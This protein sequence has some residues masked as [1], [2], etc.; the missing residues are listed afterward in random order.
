MAAEEALSNP[1]PVIQATK[2]ARALLSTPHCLQRRMLRGISTAEI[3]E[4]LDCADVKVLEHHPHDYR[5]DIGPSP[6]CL[7]LGWSSEGRPLHVVV[8]YATG[9]IVTTYEPTLPDWA[10]PDQK[11]P[12]E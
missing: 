9:W 8:A 7:V 11:G 12:R 10:A 6:S 5:P 2:H 4:A 3:T 1:L